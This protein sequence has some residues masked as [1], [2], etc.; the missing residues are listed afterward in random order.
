MQKRSHD[1]KR[2]QISQGYSPTVERREGQVRTSRESES[3]SGTHSLTSTAGGT[4]QDIKRKRRSEGYSPPF[5]NRAR[6]VRTPRESKSNRRTLTLC[7]GQREG[8]V[9]T[10]RDSKRAR[11]T[12]SL[13]RTGG[14]ISQEGTKRKQESEGHSRT[15]RHG[16]RDKSGRQEKAREQGALTVC[17]A[18]RD[19]SGR[20]EKAREREVLT[21]CRAQRGGQVRTPTTS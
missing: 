3:A 14:R 21:A 5:E 13:S 10:T 17:Q 15:M 19:K 7:R 4:G 20:Q 11:D 1:T 16:G 18:Q 8:L 2:K 6:Q 9:W 12:H